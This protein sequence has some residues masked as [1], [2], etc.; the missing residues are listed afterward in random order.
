VLGPSPF[1]KHFA[2]LHLFA[3]ADARGEGRIEA[4]APRRASDRLLAA[5]ATSA[6]LN[7]MRKPSAGKS[8]MPIVYVHVIDGSDCYIPVPTETVAPG[9]FRLLSSPDFDPDDVSC[10]WSFRPGDIIS[11]KTQTLR[12]GE[13]VAVA[14]QFG[15]RA[16][17][18]DYNAFLFGLLQGT[19]A[20]GPDTATAFKSH[21]SR[22]LHEIASGTWHYPGVK[23]A[24]TELAE[25]RNK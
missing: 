17:A 6:T 9:V 4:R 14:A 15:P 25:I 7:V 1:A 8:P 12:S 13:T 16:S 21:V 20:T 23:A 3:H 11:T 2:S 10:L 18:I 24:A 5:L 22:L 19:I